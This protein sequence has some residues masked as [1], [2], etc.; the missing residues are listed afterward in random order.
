MKTSTRSPISGDIFGGLTAM[1]V[2][3][4]S[5]IAYALIVFAP[6]GSEFTGQA[7]FA[8]I[9]G[10]FALGLV[11]GVFGGTPRLIS[12]PCA[13]A[14]AVLSVFAAT[15]VA[16]GNLTP[17]RI[18]LLLSLTA[19]LA[20]LT[21]LL[22]GRLGGGKIIKYIPY[23][24]V[25][26]Y[27]SGVGMIIILGQLPKLLGA[28]KEWNLWQLLT[29]V[30]AWHWQ[31]IVVGL[32]SIAIM[33]FAGKLIKAIPAAI[34]ALIGG[35][36][37]YFAIGLFDPSL[38]VLEHNKMVIGSIPVAGLG[39]FSG[40]VD[41]WSQVFNLGPADFSLLLTPVLTLA[42]LLSIDTLKTC[43]ILDVVTHSRHKSNQ[44]LMG[45]G[46][47]NIAAGLLGGMPGAGTMGAT[48]VNL[49]SGAQTKLSAILSG[50]F[51]LLV[52]L[53]LLPIIAWL[54]VAALAGIL[55]V[56]GFRM[57]D[58]HSLHLLRHH[59]ARFDF[60]VILAVIVAALSFS[61]IV[62]SGV[63]ITLAIV[64]FLRDQLRSSVVRRKISGDR[65]FSRKSR[66]TE[67]HQLLESSGN[68][69][70]VFEIQGQLFFGTADQLYT[71][72]EAYFRTSRYL[73]LNMRNV[74]SVDY[75][76]ANMLRQIL[77]QVTGFGG[78][79][80]L[81]SVPR[82]LPTGANAREY[83]EEL[84]LVDDANHIRFFPDL[85][86][87]LE[88]AEDETI[89][90]LMEKR[91]DEGADLDLGDFELF[92]DFFPDHLAKF[93][94]KA[95]EKVYQDGELIFHQGDTGRELYLIR[96]GEVKVVLPLGA[97]QEFHLAT[98]NR[99]GFFGDMAF[100]DKETRS[101][102]ARARGRVSLYVLHREAFDEA[103]HE[104]PQ[105]ASSFFEKLSSVISKRLRK[106][107]TAVAALQD[108]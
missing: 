98:F 57:I 62:A 13:P 106:S 55:I 47:G 61:L 20:G 11:A 22:V 10:T 90:E 53:L 67:Q 72:M 24:V 107:H 16:Q 80:V 46:M 83:L 2:A 85:D 35:T 65:M 12:A 1:L 39:Y 97:S 74:Q 36:L 33:I 63:G 50:T 42:A 28:P 73:I 78:T 88:F 89:R 60:A 44:E 64:L 76:A 102:D 91:P 21:Q 93:R 71:E 92:A 32:V 23:P 8:G 17:P 104:N 69:T 38:L 15:L 79:L 49:N 96:A 82:S 54:P 52:A 70:M 27:L 26:G 43:V 18:L 48:M 56:V 59:D 77:G 4:P 25:A 66:P 95:E 105:A 58:R 100:L 84:G 3:L 86:A 29:G 87:A 41:S 103:A 75:T 34:I 51:S 19:V 5:A 9:V 14:A 6:L 30:Q 68:R 108:S 81:A 101:A 94:A 40:L 37:S 45:Q 31:G 7:A 99:G